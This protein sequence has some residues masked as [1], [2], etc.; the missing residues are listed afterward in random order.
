MNN[1][2]TAIEYLAQDITRLSVEKALLQEALYAERV[3][4]EELEHKL[5]D[6]EERLTAPNKKGDK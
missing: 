5:A 2:P 4:N 3:K 6:L 1:K